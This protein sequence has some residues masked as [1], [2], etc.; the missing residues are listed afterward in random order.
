[1]APPFTGMC[2]GGPYDGR[3]V[4]MGTNLLHANA[5]S[6][7]QMTY[8]HCQFG[9]AAIWKPIG[10]SLEETIAHMAAT[11]RKLPDG[12]FMSGGDGTPGGGAGGVKVAPGGV[13][14]GTKPVPARK[15]PGEAVVPASAAT[16]LEELKSR[17]RALIQVHNG[18]TDIDPVYV[19]SQ[20]LNGSADDAGVA[21]LSA[22]ADVLDDGVAH[23]PKNFDEIEESDYTVSK[24]PRLGPGE[25][26][27]LHSKSVLS[28]TACKRISEMVRQ[29]I[30]HTPL[31]INGDEFTPSVLKLTPS[32]LQRLTEI[33][34]KIEA[35]AK[36]TKIDPDML[37]PF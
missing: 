1:M 5:G 2:V 34:Y 7:N 12:Y 6:E 13:G 11:H 37:I 9:E 31:I 32:H 17:L 20:L 33:E 4:S 19:L 29:Q 3:K 18:R 30:G 28:E 24:L 27:V 26:L 15:A 36:H 10:W 8:A 35:L 22:Y 14:G 16:Q 23:A 21:A 25:T